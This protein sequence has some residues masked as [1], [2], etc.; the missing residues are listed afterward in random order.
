MMETIKAFARYAPFV[1][2]GLLTIFDTAVPNSYWLDVARVH[3]ADGVVGTSPKM[4]VARE[5]TRPFRGRWIAT[6]K[7][8]QDEAET[9]PFYKECVAVGE[10]D[11]RPETVF[12]PNLDLNWWTF[13]VQC[14]LP[15]GTYI[16]DTSWKFHVMFLERTVRVVS[17]VFVIR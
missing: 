9:S 1:F 12:P 10:A 13:P 4:I 11:Y 8:A 6:V 15:P 17:N 5:V 2:V 14:E 16:V 3:V 7:K